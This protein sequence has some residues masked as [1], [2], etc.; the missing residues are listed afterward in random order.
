[1]A[2]MIYLTL[3]GNK[4]G[5]MS[6]G[7]S[8]IESIGNKC[9]MAHIDQ[10]QLLAFKHHISCD[11]YVN[12]QPVMLIKA[13]DK[14]TPLLGIAISTKEELTLVIDCY[15]TTTNGGQEKYFTIKIN[16]AI[17]VDMSVDYP[18]SVNHNEV[19]PEEVISVRYG[20]ISWQHHIAGTS[21]YSIWDDRVW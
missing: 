12:H 17:I 8:S 20:D 1:M 16:R 13:I 18:H 15:R 21:G 5:M 6:N 10:I 19:Q 7:C 2:N 4:Q 9:Q 14:A 11:Q 3:T